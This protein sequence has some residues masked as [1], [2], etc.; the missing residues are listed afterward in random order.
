MLFNNGILELAETKTL[1]TSHVVLNSLNPLLCVSVSV[2]VCLSLTKPNYDDMVPTEWVDSVV[3]RNAIMCAAVQGF[4]FVLFMLSISLSH[5]HTHSH[6]HFHGCLEVTAPNAGYKYPS[7]TGAYP[8]V[9]TCSRLFRARTVCERVLCTCDIHFLLFQ[10]VYTVSV[11][12]Y[13]D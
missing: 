1:L 7:R 3:E 12:M 8:R 10:C 4:F 11:S 2:C 9:A 5:T 13:C 6:T